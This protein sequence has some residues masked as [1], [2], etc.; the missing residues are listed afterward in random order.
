MDAKQSEEAT[1]NLQIQKKNLQK[2]YKFGKN[3]KIVNTKIK[4]Q[5]DIINFSDRLGKT[6]CL[7]LLVT[8]RIYMRSS[9]NLSRRRDSH[10]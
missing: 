8:S 1:K 2:R 4:I 3:Y 10:P 6:F 5:L 9:M 7:R